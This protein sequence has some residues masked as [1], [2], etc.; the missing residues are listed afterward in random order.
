M[1]HGVS[2]M[3]LALDLAR[4]LRPKRDV[5]LNL[6]MHK[7]SA[8]RGRPYVPMPSFSIEYARACREE[9]ENRGT[10]EAYPR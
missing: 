1:N 7:L 9:S 3:D 2:E 4:D 10:V 8:L 6:E 5:N